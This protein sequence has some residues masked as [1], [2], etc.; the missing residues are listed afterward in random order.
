MLR[1]RLL[2]WL[3]LLNLGLWDIL[4]WLDEGKEGS[5]REEGKEDSEDDEN[6]SP[7][8]ISGWSIN[9]EGSDVGELDVVSI[10]VKVG[11]DILEESRTENPWISL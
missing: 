6:S 1:N 9:R 2:N 4:D 8:S 7:G 3:G 5:E 11:V 10:K